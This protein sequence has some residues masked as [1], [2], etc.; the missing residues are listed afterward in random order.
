MKTYKGSIASS[1]ILLLVISILLASGP[2]AT[3]VSAQQPALPKGVARGASV[4]GINEYRLDNGLRVLLFPDQSKQTITANLT[5]MVGS[6]HENYGETGMA[7]LLEHLMFKGTPT[8]PNIPQELTEHGGQGDATTSFDRTNYFLTF[9]ATDANLEWVLK[10]EADRMVNSNIAKKDLDSE[11]TV[12]RNEFESGEN[13]PSLA[14]FKRIFATAFDWHNYANLPIGARSDIENVPIERLQ[15]FYRT[16]YQPDNSVLLLAGKFDEGKA[17]SLISE[18]F[19]K[20]PRPAR[21]L[22][23]IYT[24][25]PTQDGERMVMVRRVGDTQLV[26]VGYKVPAGSHPDFAALTIL[27]YILGDTPSGRLHK[28]LVETKKAASAGG[29]TLPLHDPGLLF[30]SAEVRKGD[31]IDAARDT[32]LQTVEEAGAK[33]PSAEEVERAR[34]SL[35]KEIELTLNSSDNVG[36][37]LSEW[38]AQGDW[39][40][41]FI[42]RDRIKK[43]TAADVQRVAAAYL[44]QSNR[45]VAQFMPTEKPDRAEIPPTPDVAALVKDYKGEAAV[46]EGEAFDPSPTSILART[47]ETK[48]PGGLELALL[49]KKT[50]GN[51]VIASLTLRFGDEKSLMNRGT[52]AQLTSQMLMRGTARHTRQQIQE[53]LDKLKARVGVGGGANSVSASIETVRENLPAVLRLVAEILREPA[54]PASEFEQLKQELLAQ[55]ESQKSEPQ[56]AALIAFNRHINPYPKSD[57]RYVSTLEESI[58]EIKAVTLDDLKKF[59]KDFYGATYAT[60]SVVGDFDAKALEGLV[61]ELFGSWKSPSTFTRLASVPR[62]ITPINQAIETPDKANAFFVA[63]QRFTMRDDDPDY[64]ALVIANYIIGGGLLN[65][66]LSTRIRQKEGISYGVGSVFSAHPIDRDAS[67]TA[68][69]IYAPQNVAKLEAAFKEEMERALKE[70]F[71]AEEVAAA[72]TG[73]LQALKIERAQDAGI[74]SKLSSYLYLNRTLSWDADFEKKIEALTPEQVSAALKKYVDPSKMTVIKAGNFAKAGAK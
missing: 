37:Q 55:I 24:L 43:V 54:F 20:I 52:A 9:S 2:G 11:M 33:A 44:K 61:G 60:M 7:H 30:F 18:T 72:K 66:R 35:L 62:E 5:Y 63:G 15:A 26:G 46:A 65:S 36:L 22:P 67:F 40:L 13:N 3:V 69:A 27:S 71:T 41:F 49:P 32:L 56:S 64:P 17:L 48:L 19:G 70:G 51:T 29:F 16:Y 73:F 8:H 47:T 28:A 53:E 1:L 42:H 4:E 23:T 50:R 68:F 45:T 38:M 12:V 31:P 59:H 34:T 25:E 57:V 74:A 39:R 21:A 14:V 10:L 6:R 58:E